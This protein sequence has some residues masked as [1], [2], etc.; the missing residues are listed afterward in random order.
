MKDKTLFVRQPLNFIDYEKIEPNAFLLDKLELFMKQN[1]INKGDRKTT[2][3]VYERFMEY[4]G[5]PEPTQNISEAE[6]DSQLN[7]AIQWIIEK[8]DSGSIEIVDVGCGNGVLLERLIQNDIFENF[9]KIFYMAI[10][11]EKKL[12]TVNDIAFKNRVHKYCDYRTLDEFY[13]E[14][15]K[16][17]NIQQIIFIRNVLHELDIYKTASLFSHISNNINM[18]DLLFIQDFLCFPKIERHNVCWDRG[19]LEDAL[20][21]FGFTSVRAIR[22]PSRSGNR[23]FNL[24][25]SIEDKSKIESPEAEKI[26]F[27]ARL[28]QYKFWSKLGALQEDGHHERLKEL[29]WL[30]FDLQFGYLTKQL[31][32]F[33][34]TY[35]PPLNNKQTEVLKNSILIN[36]I[37][38]FIKQNTLAPSKLYQVKGFRERGK[39]LNIGEIFLRHKERRLA[40]VYGGKSFGKR[41]FITQLLSSRSYDK[42]PIIINAEQ[43]LDCWNLIEEF[44]SKC[45]LLISK[46]KCN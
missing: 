11:E 34:S 17:R 5:K 13:R 21:K 23:W 45:G 16:D 7:T 15:P 27:H 6:Y 28:D 40:I 33:D 31:T 26:V 9:K 29:E 24:T 46:K 22:I 8:C 19:F 1:E 30:D 36:S 10:D 32:D 3:N 41:T 12:S 39:Q 4:Y 42:T 38:Q 43:G 18:N 20:K 35:I 25:A 2:P 37:D 14:W 44:L